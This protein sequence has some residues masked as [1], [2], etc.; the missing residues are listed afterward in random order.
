MDGKLPF[1]ADYG[2]LFTGG[3]TAVNLGRSTDQDWAYAQLWVN[4]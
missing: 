2:H 4:F 1:Q 3:Y